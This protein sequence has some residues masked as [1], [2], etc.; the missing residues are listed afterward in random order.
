[1]VGR[2]WVVKAGGGRLVV[3]DGRQAVGGGRQ[4]VGGGR[5]VV[6]VAVVGRWW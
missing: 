5:Q 6:R 3:G 1:M 2:W 4:V